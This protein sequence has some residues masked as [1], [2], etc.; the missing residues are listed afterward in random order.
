MA[1]R[2]QSAS[3]PESTLLAFKQAY[4]LGVD[5]LETD[6]RLTRDHQVVLFH[7]STLT[8][9]TNV[10][11]KLSQYSLPELKTL[12][13]GYWFQLPGQGDFPFRGQGH[14]I[15]TLAEFLGAFPRVRVNID[16]KN[17]DPVLPGLVADILKQEGAEDRVI[18]ASFHQKQIYLFRQIA[19]SRV[20]T[21]AGPMEVL[22][23]VI[24]SACGRP[25]KRPP[26]YAAF[27]VPVGLGPIKIVTPRKIAFAHEKGVAMQVWTINDPQK[28]LQLME[29]GVDGIFTD[30]PELL[31][32]IKRSRQ[33]L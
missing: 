11:G 26:S 29:W 19:G 9:T 18:V 7:D 13:L 3:V 17:K 22:H 8:R 33:S 14:H 24:G 23:F 4:D 32:Q 20:T 25:F 12:D 15:L 2:G 5:F 31:L 30:K 27:Q 16:L 1:H 28:M 10:G 6:A 21:S